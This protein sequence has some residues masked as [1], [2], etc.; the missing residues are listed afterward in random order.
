M[1]IGVQTLGRKLRIK[2]DVNT[3]TWYQIMIHVNRTIE[4]LPSKTQK[5]KHRKS[6]LAEAGAHLQSVRLAW[7]NEVMHPKQT[8]TRQE[9]YDVFNATKTFMVFLA[10]LV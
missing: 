10:D 9:A 8:Y 6:R 1:E 4:K 2:I 5:E 7:R 3:E